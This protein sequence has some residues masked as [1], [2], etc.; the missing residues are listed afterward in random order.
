MHVFFKRKK[1]LSLLHCC[2]ALNDKLWVQ[3]HRS[4][5]IRLHQL[6]E[7]KY[8]STSSHMYFQNKLTIPAH[9]YHQIR[10]KKHKGFRLVIGADL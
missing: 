4:K 3:G 10:L 8:K 2:I 6:A 1:L 5:I 9:V 7:I